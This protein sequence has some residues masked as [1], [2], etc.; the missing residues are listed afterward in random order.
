MTELLQNLIDSG[1]NIS[2][3]SYEGNWGEVD[4]AFD[5]KLYNKK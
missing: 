2:A 3:I 4:S 1:L 5:L